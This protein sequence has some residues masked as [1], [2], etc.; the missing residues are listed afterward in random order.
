MDFWASS[1]IVLLVGAQVVIA[2]VTGTVIDRESGEPLFGVI[3]SLD[4]LGRRALTDSSGRY[5][6]VDVPPGPQHVSVRR[7]GYAPR[8]FHALVPRQGTIAIDVSLQPRPIALEAIEATTRIPLRGFDEGT[9]AFPDR[10]VSIA[11]ARHHPLLSEPDALQAVGGGEVVLLPESPSGLHIRG[12]A[13]DQVAYLLDGI[14]VLNPYHSA[15]VFSAWNPDALS[16]VDLFT[17]ASSPPFPDALSGVVAATTRAPGPQLQTQ[18]ALSTTQARLTL[19]GLLGRRGAGYL[20]SLRNGYPGLLRHRQE[21][22]HLRGESGDWLAK[23]ESPLL[24]GRVQLLGYGSGTSLEVANTD[25]TGG[26]SEGSRNSLEWES[27]SGGMIWR[28]SLRRATLELRAWNALGDAAA[29]WDSRDSLPPDLL[30]SERRDQG[31]AAMIELR[32]SVTSTL[33]GV[34]VQRNE[35]LYWL[36]PASGDGRSLRLEGRTPIA[37]GFAQ[38]TRPVSARGT[39][40]L[41][42]TSAVAVSQLHLDPAA[43]LRWKLSST[44]R[45][46]SEYSRRHQFSQSLRNP[47]SIVGNI[48]PADLSVGAG[49]GVPVARS[50]LGIVSIE[51]RPTAAIRLGTQAYAR[52]FRSLALVAPTQGEPF[53]TRGFSRGSGS[54]HG[55]SLQAAANGARYGFIADY[56]FQSVRFEYGDSS[57]VP[58]V[59]AGHSI[60]AGIVFFP[61]STSSVRLGVS[62]L[63]GRRGT[64][65]LGPVEWEACNLLD[66][67]CEFAGSPNQRSGPLGGTRLPPYLRVD[68]GLRQ[69]WHL[70]VAGR[71]VQM[72]V[73]GSV[74]NLLA[75]RNV[76]TIA[77]DPVTG[78]RRNIEMRPRSP[79]VV[80]FD[81]RF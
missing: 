34:R 56:G 59:G 10:R 18:G 47:E 9:A 29:D 42:L 58:N 53:A 79:L 37:A 6:L 16:H 14:P 78:Q 50:D 32:D 26:S 69:H 13:A 20:L 51:Y 68:L 80:G 71:D 31:A 81:W 19:D 72:A 4:D 15:G 23:V 30:T 48:F 39:L 52:N 77:V 63:L 7:I 70:H 41:S 65:L 33:A 66:E 67:G 12:G 5:V 36:R 43:R 45:V 21:A 24:G 28:R 3:V 22:S 62:S 25:S 2:S 60:E 27:S 38:H 54:A 35:T 61:W 74:T 55:A 57:Y 49:A 44:V 75:R 40:E 64:A 73:F 1:L 11:A 76:L 17:T 8:T 46:T